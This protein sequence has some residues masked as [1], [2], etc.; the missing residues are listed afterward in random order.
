M[1]VTTPDAST[2]ASSRD[3]FMYVSPMDVPGWD[4]SMDVSGG[5]ACMIVSSW[6]A[7]GSQ[8]GWLGGRSP[9]RAESGWKH[10][11]SAWARI[12]ISGSSAICAGKKAGA[13]HRQTMHERNLC[14]SVSRRFSRPA[15]QLSMLC[16]S[17][18]P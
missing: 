17:S 11:W 8:A 7:G 4:T 18:P 5:D 1:D 15:S 6:A 9:V 3:A 12:S 2:D 10:S 13:G 14:G 16:A